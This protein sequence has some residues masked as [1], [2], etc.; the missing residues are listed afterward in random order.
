MSLETDLRDVL[1]SDATVSAL[2]A[3]R[4]YPVIRAQ[5][6]AVPAIS[7][8]LVSGQRETALRGACVTRNGRFQVDSWARDYPVAKTLAEAVRVALLATSRFAC[9]PGIE[10]DLPEPD[11]KLYRV[12][13]EYSLWQNDGTGS[14][15]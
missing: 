8:Q 2:V 11:V 3:N 13:S 10:L 14:P 5:E 15:S 9:V 12:M 6:S 7:Y 1:A 4:I